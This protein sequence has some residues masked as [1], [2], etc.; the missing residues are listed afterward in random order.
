MLPEFYL[1]E[2]L[3]MGIL[4]A[5]TFLGNPKC[6][7]VMSGITYQ[8]F[9]VVKYREVYNPKNTMKAVIAGQKL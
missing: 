1:L 5:A 6:L 7:G 2:N 9:E 4:D 3:I 8:F